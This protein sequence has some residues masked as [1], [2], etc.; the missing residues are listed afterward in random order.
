M[1]FPTGWGRQH[2]ITIDAT[3]VAG[4]TNLTDYPI[5]LTEAN[6]MTEAFDNSDNGGML[7]EIRVSSVAR[8][9]DWITTEY[10]NQNDPST[11][12]VAGTPENV[13]TK[14]YSSE[15]LENI[16][17]M[18]DDTDLANAFSE[19]DYTDVATENSVFV[20]QTYLGGRYGVFLLKDSNAN[21]TDGIYVI[22]KGTN[23]QIDGSVN[24]EVYNRN[25]ELW[26]AVDN[27][28][29]VP[30]ELATLEGSIETDLEN[31]YDENHVVA[32]RVFS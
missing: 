22:W 20:N 24:L 3:K 8:T 31:Y 30:E 26:E 18:V 4:A 6:F 5:L 15:D 28:V 21:S 11:F 19:Q 17:T 12:A 9:D 16:G 1:A 7:D 27:A 29:T 10:N 32:F 14:E 25:T 2:K 23:S 13:A